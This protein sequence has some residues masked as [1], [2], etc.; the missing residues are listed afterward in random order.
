[1]VDLTYGR[2][3]LWTVYCP[4]RLIEHDIRLDGVDFRALPEA[5]SSV[6][7]AVFDPPYIA[8]G[9]RDSTNQISAIGT[10]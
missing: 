7:V 9:G 4:A 5:S 1:M 3:G 2:G 6:D 10:G 8:Q